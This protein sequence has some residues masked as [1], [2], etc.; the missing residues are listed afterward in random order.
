MKLTQSPAGME[1]GS[2][3][4]I[5]RSNDGHV[6]FDIDFNSLIFLSITYSS[7]IPNLVT[8]GPLFLCRSFQGQRSRY[9]DLQVKNDFTNHID[10]L[11]ETHNLSYMEFER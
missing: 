3:V 7:S 10:I 1:P 9:N 11:Q 8:I 5:I 6:R 4:S 2:S